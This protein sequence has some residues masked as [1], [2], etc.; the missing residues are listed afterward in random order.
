MLPLLYVNLLYPIMEM[1]SHT[2][3][4]NRTDKAMECTQPRDK[5]PGT[6]HICVRGLI[7]YTKKG[8]SPLTIEGIGRVQNGRGCGSAV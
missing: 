1:F 5:V 2:D 8:E 7:E 6:R 3:T 4:G